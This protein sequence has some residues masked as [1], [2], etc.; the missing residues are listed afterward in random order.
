MKIAHHSLRRQR[1]LKLESLEKRQLLAGMVASDL[2]YWSEDQFIVRRDEAEAVELWVDHWRDASVFDI[3]IDATVE[4]QSDSEGPWS[5]WSVEAESGNVSVAENG[6]SILYQPA[7]GFTGIDVVTLRKEVDANALTFSSKSSISEKQFAVNVVEPL[8]AV[9]DWFQVDV[10][11]EGAELDVLANDIRNARYIGS[12]PEFRLQSVS[13]AEEDSIAVSGSVAVSEDLKTLSYQPPVGFEGTQS[14]SYV[15]MDQSGYLMHGSVEVR[16]SSDW[17]PTLW[18][19]QLEQQMTQFA[20]TQNQYRFG[21]PVYPQPEIRVLMDETLSTGSVSPDVSGTNNQIADVEESDRIKTDGEFLYV[22][23]SPD[24]NDWMGWG[25]F[26][27][28]G[29]R[30]DLLEKPVPEASNLLT[31]IDIRQPSFPVIVSR[32]LFED[33]VISLDLEG[34]RLTV[35]SQRNLQTS[36]TVL[37]VSEPANAKNVWSTVVDGEFRQARRVGGMLYVFTVEGNLRVPPLEKVHA[38]DSRFKFYET[39]QD[40]VDGLS[41]EMLLQSFFASQTVFDSDGI[42]VEGI[43]SFLIDPF[44][45]GILGRNTSMNL[46][47]FDTA[48]SVGGAIDWE[49]TDGSEHLLVTTDSIYT[50]RTNYQSSHRFDGSSEVLIGIP[51]QPMITTEIDRFVLQSDGGIAFESSGVVPGTLNNSFSIDEHNGFLRIATENSWWSADVENQGSNVYVLEPVAESMLVVGGLQGLAPGEQIYAVRFA[52]DRGYV[53]TFERVDPL[54]VID[55]GVPTEPAL[56]GQLKTPGY[57]QYLHVISENHL[58]GIGRD[59]DEDTGQYGGLVVSLFNVSDPSLPVVQDR[60]EIDGGRSTFSPFAEDNPWELRDHHAIS[61]FSEFGI[62]AL[63]IYSRQS[64]AFQGVDSPV[65]ESSDQSAVRT[66][67]IDPELG[68]G[69]MDTVPFDSRADRTLRVGEYLYSLSNQELKVTHLLQRDD[70]VASL[71]FEGDGQDDYFDTLVGEVITLD[72]TRNDLLGQGDLAVLNAELIDGDGSLEIVDGKSIRFTPLNHKLSEQRIRY[73][74]RN[75]AGT[76]INAIATIDPDMRWQNSISIL[77]VNNDSVTSSRDALNVINQLVRYGAVDCEVIEELIGEFNEERP[78]YYF[79]T[80]G[81]RRLSG[82][83]ALLIINSLA[84]GVIPE[85]EARITSE[86]LIAANGAAGLSQTDQESRRDVVWDSVQVT[87][88]NVASFDSLAEHKQIAIDLVLGEA[89]DDEE[90]W[91][92]VEPFSL[93]HSY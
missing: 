89:W 37:D 15:A 75:A 57:S 3:G 13:I 36:V 43:E 51:E 29:L 26:P 8:L 79:D 5:G 59:A 33:R 21:G 72:V 69:V 78:H 84:Q 25:I 77:D 67:G 22:L 28:M 52:G 68:I 32:R 7:V 10:N 12:Q 70:L 2:P 66:F 34:E 54:F 64:S 85:G 48:Q 17:R 44:E 39:G 76:L 82:R 81:D 55:L 56:L 49:L 23:S 31:I 92:D 1:K 47:A 4:Q 50:T 24:K 9:D 11:S 91:S 80:T 58:L 74:A 53:V 88:E 27:W 62:L 61:Y 46:I 60:Y 16:V 20:V 45:I 86:K 73:T 14:I 42:L 90:S 83:D 6:L 35:I 30:Q 65:F 19:E 71:V 18:P 40:Y 93:E 38:V 41:E 63:P 87:S